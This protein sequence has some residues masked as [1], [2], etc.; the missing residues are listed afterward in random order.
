M[1]SLSRPSTP[2]RPL[3]AAALAALAALSAAALPVAAATLTVNTQVTVAIV[4]TGSGTRLIESGAPRAIRVSGENNN[5]PVV[6]LK[7]FRIR[8]W[9]DQTLPVYGIS[10]EDGGALRL[11]DCILEWFNDNALGHDAGTEATVF[12]STFSANR[13]AAI[14]GDG[15]LVL[16][17]STLS[18]NEG[19][20]LR[21]EGG[22][23]IDS[24]VIGGNRSSSHGG[25]IYHAPSRGGECLDVYNTTISGS[26]GFHDDDPPTA[27]PLLGPLWSSNAPSRVGFHP[28][29]KGSPAINAGQY[30]VDDVLGK[31]TRGYPRP[32]DHL[33]WDL[34]SYE[35][36]PYE[37]ELLTV[38][39]KSSDAHTVQVESGYSNGAGTY[40]Q[41][42]AVGDYVTYAAFNPESGSHQLKIRVKRGSNRPKV[43]VS[44]SH[45]P[46]LRLH[47]RRQRNRPLQQQPHLLHPDRRQL[48]RHRRRLPR[49]AGQHPAE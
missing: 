10:V 5:G 38:M 32:A 46:K 20:G 41:A 14:D 21:T 26:T 1:R 18:Q 11:E 44:F 9:Q 30:F 24:C 37:T 8:K 48:Q 7:G 17:R 35:V 47:R 16:K 31:D 40:L 12:N 45:S 3:P 36:C 22:A 2:I 34:G 49:A 13:G 39:N 29:L 43:R 27:D 42:D 33:L 6:T 28:L 25:G 19:G 23:L 4:G 15:E